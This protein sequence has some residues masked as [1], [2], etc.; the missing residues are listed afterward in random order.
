MRWPHY[1]GEFLS[2]DSSGPLVVETRLE[3]LQ[4]RV[5]YAAEHPM[6]SCVKGQ[7]VLPVGHAR[8]HRFVT[9]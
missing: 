1:P 9:V 8:A 4:R 2:D 7:C 3:A 5:R 6:K